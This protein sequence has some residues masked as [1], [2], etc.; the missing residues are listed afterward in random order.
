MSISRTHGV[1]QSL[2][3]SVLASHHL[4]CNP[5]TM[6]DFLLQPLHSQQLTL[7][8]TEVCFSPKIVFHRRLSS[9]KCLLPPNVFF[10][11]SSSSTKG[12]L[13]PKVIFHQ[14]S[15]STKGCLPLKV[16]FHHHASCIMHHA[17]CRM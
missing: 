1:C 4:L 2:S 10:H 11:Q 14:R 12:C 8:S 16:V 6:F 9:T 17:S 5:K 7:S 3:Y 13:P 15:S